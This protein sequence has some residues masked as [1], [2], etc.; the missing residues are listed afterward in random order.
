MSPGSESRR[1]AAC[2][3]AIDS[4]VAHATVEMDF[5]TL[6]VQPRLPLI[7]DT[8]YLRLREVG[9]PGTKL[10]HTLDRLAQEHG[11]PQ[12]M[13]VVA[14]EAD[15]ARLAKELAGLLDM[16][17]QLTMVHRGPAEPPPASRFEVR[18]A[19]L[20]ELA[21]LRR[22]AILAEPWGGEEIAHQLLAYDR[23]IERVAAVLYLTI[24]V[25]GKV[26]AGCRL[27]SRGG[28]AEIDDLATAP[29]CRRQGMASA[30]LAAA[31]ERSVS[32]GNA[33]TYLVAN[34]DGW[35]PSF[36]AKHGFDAT[37]ISHRFVKTLPP[38]ARPH[39][40]LG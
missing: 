1:V 23:R 20:G 12:L 33:I 3:A 21:D 38:L 24:S 2:Q 32:Q 11:V 14:N 39:C 25:E 16:D 15:G 10:L 31:V 40:R 9:V 18:D 35:Q 4:A 5:G 37:S 28:V 27:T 34:A 26:V 8:N 19:V 29:P 6:V 17:R 13:L 22:G 36:Y 7:W 30:L